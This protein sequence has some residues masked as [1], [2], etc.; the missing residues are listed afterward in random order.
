M[1]VTKIINYVNEN[2]SLNVSLFFDDNI[3]ITFFDDSCT[4]EKTIFID[5]GI[6]TEELINKI[7]KELDKIRNLWYNNI[8]SVQW[9][10]TLITG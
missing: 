4:F 7:T 9:N 10:P 5:Y 2:Y 8:V 3:Q 6:T 1:E